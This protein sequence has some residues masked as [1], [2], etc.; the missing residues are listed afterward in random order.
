MKFRT[1]SHAV[2]DLR[3]DEADVPQCHAEFVE[4]RK[5]AQSP[6]DLFGRYSGGRIL[7]HDDPPGS[8]P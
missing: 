2:L 3:I 8:V 7:S 4:L 6:L 1:P 5:L